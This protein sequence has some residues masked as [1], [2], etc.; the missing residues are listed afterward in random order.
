[1]KKVLILVMAL[2]LVPAVVPAK[3]DRSRLASEFPDWKRR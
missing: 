1:M 3:A 2:A